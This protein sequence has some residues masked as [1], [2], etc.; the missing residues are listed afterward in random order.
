M[1]IVQG[2]FGSSEIKKKSCAIHFL[3]NKHWLCNILEYQW[4]PGADSRHGLKLLCQ[5]YNLLL[6]VG[7]P[8]PSS[9]VG[10]AHTALIIMVGE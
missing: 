3:L 1:E 7:R 5:S 2:L 8:S 9:A 6:P 10:M 4:I